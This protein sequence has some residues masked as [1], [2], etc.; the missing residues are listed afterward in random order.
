M[1]VAGTQCEGQEESLLDCPRTSDAEIAEEYGYFGADFSGTVVACGTTSAGAQ[2]PR[3]PER[4]QL[5]HAL[6]IKYVSRGWL[7][8]HAVC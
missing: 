3:T 5:L 2:Q 6:R 4:H 7:E 1:S 8:A